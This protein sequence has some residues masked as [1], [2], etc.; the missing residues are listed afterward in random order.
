[1]WVSWLVRAS[2]HTL[3]LQSAMTTSQITNYPTPFTRLCSC[4]CSLQLEGSPSSCSHTTSCSY[5]YSTVHGGL[6]KCPTR[7]LVGPQPGSYTTGPATAQCN[8]AFV[9]QLCPP[10]LVPLLAAGHQAAALE[11]FK[12]PQGEAEEA[13]CEGLWLRN[14]HVIAL[15]LAGVTSHSVHVRIITV[16]FEVFNWGQKCI[17]VFERTWRKVL[18]VSLFATASDYSNKTCIF[19]KMQAHIPVHARLVGVVICVREERYDYMR[20]V[21]KPPYGSIRTWRHR[22]TGKVCTNSNRLQWSSRMCFTTMP[23]T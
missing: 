20:L 9:P 10:L 1:M 13:Q 15:P 5:S 18:I 12:C 16:I 7:T 2:M 23:S 17:A 22:A 8:S 14:G 3:T 19:C 21:P 6:L 4:E 11:R